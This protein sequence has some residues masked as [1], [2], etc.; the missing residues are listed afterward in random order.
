MVIAE[1]KKVRWFG[2]LV[3]TDKSKE[4]E[5]PKQKENQKRE[6]S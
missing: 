6:T 5:N 4:N 2:Y 1:E 3:R